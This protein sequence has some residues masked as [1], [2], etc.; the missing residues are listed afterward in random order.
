MRRSAASLAA[1]ISAPLAAPTITFA[2]FRD[3]GGHVRMGF[4][5]IGKQGSGHL[6]G[7]AWTFLPGGF[8]ARNDVQVLAVCDVWKD[9]RENAAAK[10]NDY[11][12]RLRRGATSE[13]CHAYN[14]FREL[15]DRQDI[16]AVLIAT[17][18]HW[19]ATMTCMAAEAGKDIYCEAPTAV[20]IQE[21]QAILA[22]ARR[23]G[24][25]YQAGTQ[26]RSDYGGRFRRACEFVRSGRIGKLKEIY[27]YRDGGG[28]A[29]PRP[30]GPAQP[31]P[32]GL[33]W[34]LFLGP[35]PGIPYD[36]DTSAQRFDLGELTWGQHHYDIVQWAVG[37]DETGATEFF[38]EK[39]RSCCRYPGGV[40]V[41]GKPCPD[42]PVGAE[43]GACFIGANG[44]IAV[45]RKRLVSN[46]PDLVREPLGPEEVHLYRSDS[47]AGNFLECIRTRGKT[48]C[49]PVI[50][51][52]SANALLLG[53]IIKQAG[54]R[55]RW[56][57]QIERFIDNDD[58]N[59]LLSMAKRPPWFA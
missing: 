44:R 53:G 1:I 6:F 10:V 52:H 43:G 51:H 50:A 59:R 57:T 47:H 2:A 32:A 24:R 5:G 35:A 36:G 18:S 14:D 48:I 17:P 20:T 38:M 40:V 29:W 55:G 45:D 31:V 28:I 7:G 41:Y 58:A 54:T 22:A 33:D 42:E 16:D 26:Q 56:D 9:R 46:P 30:F 15:L 37:A 8:L 4:I 13:A 11:Y 49:D 39:N 12:A 27:A 3:G 23:Y 19:H 34:D 25:V 21:S